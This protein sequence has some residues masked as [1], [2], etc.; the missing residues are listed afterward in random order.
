MV[1]ELP[2]R[3][4][5]DE[6]TGILC[7]RLAHGVRLGREGDRVDELVEGGP[8]LVLDVLLPHRGKLTGEVANGRDDVHLVGERQVGHQPLDLPARRGAV[9][10]VREQ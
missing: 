7:G 2:E 8:T 6:W 10:L 5:L 9:E 4:V 1:L 3:F